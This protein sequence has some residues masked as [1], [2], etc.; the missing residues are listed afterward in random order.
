MVIAA[1]RFMVWPLGRT[2]IARYRVGGYWVVAHKFE[3]C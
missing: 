3:E 2:G 1:L